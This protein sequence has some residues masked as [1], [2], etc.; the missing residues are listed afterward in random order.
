MSK[1]VV[2]GKK[3]LSQKP[4]QANLAKEAGFSNRLDIS[5]DLKNELAKMGLVPRW[6]NA[7]K[8]YENQGY[9]EKGW[10]PYKSTVHGAIDLPQF[11]L[12][13]DPDGVIR[14]GDCILGVKPMDKVAAHRAYLRQKAQRQSLYNKQQ[15]AALRKQASSQNIDMTIHEGYEDNDDE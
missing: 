10:V 5:D 8:L 1:G 11:K 15:A 7:K 6:M 4:R 13:N 3:P 2:D 14:R 12:G 9:H